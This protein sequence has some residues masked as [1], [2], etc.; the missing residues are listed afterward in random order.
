VRERRRTW[1]ALGLLALGLAA[2]PGCDGSES[3]ELTPTGATVTPSTEDGADPA[4]R[5]KKKAR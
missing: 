2:S 4:A 1:L 5:T 3:G